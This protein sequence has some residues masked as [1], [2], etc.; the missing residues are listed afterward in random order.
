MGE[1]TLP[2][3]DRIVVAAAAAGDGDVYDRDKSIETRHRQVRYQQRGPGLD[4][5]AHQLDGWEGRP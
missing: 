5:E 1:R 2:K 4:G 3:G